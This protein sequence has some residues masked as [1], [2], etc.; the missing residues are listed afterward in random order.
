[1][2]SQ[3]IT[4]YRLANQQ[5]SVHNCK[6]PAEVVRHLG[7]MQ[8]QDYPGALWAIGLR[9]PGSTQLDIEKAI[10]DRQI[11]R[12]WPMRGTLHFV[13]AE[14]IKWMIELMTPRIFKKMASRHRQLELTEEIFEKSRQII[15]KNLQGDKQITRPDMFKLLEDSGIST[16]DQ[17]GAHILGTLAQRCLICFASHEGKQPT[18]AL[19]SEWAPQ[20]KSLPRDESLAKITVRYFSGHGPATIQDFVWWTGLTVADAKAGLEMVKTKLIKES[21]DGKEYWMPPNTQLSEPSSN[22]YLLPGFDEYMLGYK[23]RTAALDL[24]HSPKVAPGGNG[25]FLPTIVINGK[26]EGLWKR[27]IKSKKVVITPKPFLSIDKTEKREF[28]EMAE[29]YAQ[30][31]RLEAEVDLSDKLALG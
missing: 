11:V 21:I 24:E 7:A 5:I 9:L 22:L 14:D 18:F 28:T 15:Q 2:T 10:A 31:L 30:Y 16:H 19:L 1:M 12:T 4:K 26:I 6:T 23:N 20:A 25:M 8:A 17:R 13:P 27:T 3:E 29:R